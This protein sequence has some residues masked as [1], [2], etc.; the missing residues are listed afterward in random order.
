MNS[1]SKRSERHQQ[2]NKQQAPRVHDKKH[3]R[4][5]GNGDLDF[6][7]GEQ[8]QQQHQG[9]EAMGGEGEVAE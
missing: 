4:M 3:E 8:Q 6:V 2:N 9:F 7:G 1:R 5:E